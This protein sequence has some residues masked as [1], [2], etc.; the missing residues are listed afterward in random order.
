MKIGPAERGIGFAE[1]FCGRLL[2]EI[3]D[4]EENRTAQDDDHAEL[5]LYE[6]DHDH[7]ER[8]QRSVEESGERAGGDE[9]A[10]LLQV[11]NIW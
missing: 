3:G 7:E 5:W 10:K 4:D 8:C 1:R 11:A 6:V 9:G 2:I